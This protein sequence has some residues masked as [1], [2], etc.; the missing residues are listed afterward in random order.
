MDIIHYLRLKHLSF[1]SLQNGQTWNSFVWLFSFG[2][3][4][5]KVENHAHIYINEFY[6][7]AKKVHKNQ[8]N[9]KRNKN[10]VI[11]IQND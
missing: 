8:F 4:F 10:K 2:L 5:K 7:N 9:T 1:K 11:L 3:Q 6:R